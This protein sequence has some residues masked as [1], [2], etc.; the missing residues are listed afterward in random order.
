M[1]REE[2]ETALAILGGGLAALG[3]GPALWAWSKVMFNIW[4]EAH[5]GTIFAYVQC[6]TQIL[7][8]GH[9]QRELELCAA[10]EWGRSPFFSEPGALAV[11]ICG[12]LLAIVG[13]AI[14]WRYR[15]NILRRLDRSSFWFLLSAMSFANG[16]I[17][18]LLAHVS[19]ERSR[20]GGVLVVA[21]HV[22][23]FVVGTARWYVTW[24]RNHPLGLWYRAVGLALLFAGMV[25]LFLAL[26]VLS[27]F[28]LS[29]AILLAGPVIR[30]NGGSVALISAVVVVGG[31]LFAWQIARRSKRRSAS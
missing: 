7:P 11:A 13:A 28:I 21:L 17:W 16:L 3:I 12:T 19:A 15:R 2:R 6:E 24:R 18:L 25:V 22:V 29:Q 1:R 10:R 20:F 30:K 5:Q 14:V 9:T 8:S 26:T 31:F 27:L 4:A 23:M